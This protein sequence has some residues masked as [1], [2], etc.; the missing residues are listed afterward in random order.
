MK[1]YKVNLRS[2]ADSSLGFVYFTSK[3]AALAHA[4][5]WKRKDPSDRSFDVS[6][7]VIEPKRGSIVQSLNTHGGHPDN[8]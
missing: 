3:R 1:I 2:K 6:L 8:G 4:H 5:G 7:L